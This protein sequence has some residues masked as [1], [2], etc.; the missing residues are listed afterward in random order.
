MESSSHAVSPETVRLLVSQ[1]IPDS[2][3]FVRTYQG[4]DHFEVQI[5]SPSFVG[6]TL[7]AQ[8]QMVYQALG[9]HMQQNIH[10]LMLKTYTPERWATL[11][12]KEQE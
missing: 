2:Q 3:I 1:H 12:V 9:E 10:A 11:T 8:H 4:D 6:K 7:I 5:I